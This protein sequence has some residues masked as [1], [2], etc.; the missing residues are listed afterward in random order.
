MIGHFIPKIMRMVNIY[1]KGIVHQFRIYNIFFVPQRKK[2]FLWKVHL[3][4]TTL[5]RNNWEKW[6]SKSVRSSTVKYIIY[7][8]WTDFEN[9]CRRLDTATSLRISEWVIW[10]HWIK[11]ERVA[12]FIHLF[13]TVSVQKRCVCSKPKVKK[14]FLEQCQYC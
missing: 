9:H 7:I 1:I 14:S 12:N 8:T 11:S 10:Q 4:K 2:H 3:D 6:C 13:S 5:T